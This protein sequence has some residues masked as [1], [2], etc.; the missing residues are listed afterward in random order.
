MKNNYNHLITDTFGSKLKL[1]LFETH[2]K[3]PNKNA[4]YFDKNNNN[5]DAYNMNLNFLK[6]DMENYSQNN[7]DRYI[8]NE[9]IK[10]EE[11]ER[12]KREKEKQQINALLNNYQQI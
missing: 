4:Y 7:P 8:N 5:I 10:W 9:I 1:N 6:S 2:F 3:N 11:K 12:K